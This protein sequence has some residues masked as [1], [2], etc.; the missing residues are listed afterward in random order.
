MVDLFIFSNY[1]RD[2]R[3][4]VGVLFTESEIHIFLMEETQSSHLRREI[5]ANSIG[6]N[7]WQQQKRVI[8]QRSLHNIHNTEAYTFN[9][10]L[11]TFTLEFQ[12]VHTI[13]QQK[14]YF[15]RN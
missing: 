2:W 13:L 10:N 8:P 15:V 3:V 11:N 14:K 5:I 4:S 6:S 7:P 1:Y 9:K 12:K